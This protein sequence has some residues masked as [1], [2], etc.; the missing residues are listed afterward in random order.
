MTPRGAGARDL[1]RTTPAQRD[2]YV[3][4]LRALSI[5]VVI[6]GHWLAVTI[7]M[8]DGRIRGRHVLEVLPAVHPLTWAFQVIGIFFLVGGYANAASWARAQRTGIGYGQWL[9]V[10]SWR[11]L[12]P[13]TVFI[14]VG[15]AAAVAARAAGVD[16][17]LVRQ[18]AWLIA[19]SLWFL[20]VYLAV[21]ALTP[22]MVGAQRRWSLYTVAVLGL[23]VA[24]GDAARLTLGDE[25]AAAANFLLVWLIAHQLGIAWRD[26]TM[27]EGRGRAWGL[28]LAGSAG[29]L[30]CTMIGPYPVSM[31]AYPGAPLQNTSPP[32]LALLALIVAQAGLVL[33]LAGPARRVLTRTSVWAAVVA[34][35]GVI[36]TLFLWHMVPVV[37]AAS[38]L[39]PIGIMPDPAVGTAGWF[40]LRPVWLMACAVAL[41]VLV[42]VFGRVERLATGVRSPARQR[43]RTTALA[44]TG[45]AGAAAGIV[46]LTVTGLQ[47][48]GPLGVPLAAV[49]TYA[50]GMA[51][52]VAVW[53][54]DRGRRPG[55]CLD[56]GVGRSALDHDGA[57]GVNRPRVT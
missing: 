47:G 9:A 38:L 14:A 23:V 3:D 30:A 27:T 51:A 49:T 36:M 13:T 26:G 7:V 31:V 10:R 24:V 28:L 57:P 18:G 12:S 50:C 45:T 40:A 46:L 2:R 20:A 42:A 25:S 19:I 5:T 44:V 43:L 1:A 22:I 55:S 39:Y 16:P 15:T 4:F 8:E 17:E 34:V 37:V 56:N 29:L 53:A 48:E 11:L 6:L 21:V 35:N 41:V 33:L 54:I 32:T 52:L